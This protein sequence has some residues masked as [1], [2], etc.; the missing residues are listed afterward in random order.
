MHM[1]LP[2]CS[3]VWLCILSACQ[4]CQEWKWV[5]VIF[6]LFVQHANFLQRMYFDK[7]AL[8]VD[9]ACFTI[10]LRWAACIVCQDLKPDLQPISGDDSCK[11]TACWAGCT[12]D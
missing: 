11:P 2:P 12:P 3:S 1:P 6:P 8:Y 4:A 5:S 7:V 9:A 10:R